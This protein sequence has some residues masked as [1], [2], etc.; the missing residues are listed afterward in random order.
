VHGDLASALPA[1]VSEVDHAE[2]EYLERSWV[3]FVPT[4]RNAPPA[5]TA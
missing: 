2:F 4:E 3:G 1:D 5:A